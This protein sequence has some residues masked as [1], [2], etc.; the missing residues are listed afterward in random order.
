MD[1]ARS[2]EVA[3][4]FVHLAT[5]GS[6]NDEIA[7]RVRRGGR[8]E[9]PEF[10]TVVTDSQTSGRGR[11]GRSWVA[12]PGTMLATSVLLWPG[13]SGIDRPD[14][15]G[16][17]PLMA[18]LA[19][20]RSVRGLGVEADLKWPND[21]MVRDRKLCGILSEYVGDG[22]VVLGA[23]INL[24]LTTEQLPVRTATSLAIEGVQA[25]PDGV[26]AG[27]LVELRSLY[28]A[29]ADS[30]GDSEASG[31]FAEV[32]VACSTIGK[33]VRVE[34]PG[35]ESLV[36]VAES[37]DGDGRLVVDSPG[38]RTAVSAGDVTHLRY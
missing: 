23:G 22:A 8:S 35:T 25:D 30:G 28:G 13:R 31:L 20:V 7:E 17:L 3:S 24:T 21:V 19:M 2:A 18:G 38:R 16:W 6:T 9:W 10:S 29:F 33:T 34:L 15:L 12:P 1:F 32:S 4:R 5:A 27:Y 37:L 14:A 11:L 36:G 26:L